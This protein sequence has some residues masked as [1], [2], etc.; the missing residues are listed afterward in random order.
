MCIVSSVNSVKSVIN[1]R[2]GVGAGE[3]LG[4]VLEMGS[5]RDQAACGVALETVRMVGKPGVWS[6]VVISN[7]GLSDC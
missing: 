4:M 1:T 2:R 7:T 6:W 3:A 5:G